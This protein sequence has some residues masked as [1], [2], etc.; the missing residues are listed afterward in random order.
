VVDEVN[1]EPGVSEGADRS[2]PRRAPVLGV[3]GG[4]G[5]GKTY[6]VRQIQSRCAA[7][8]MR[9]AH[10]SFDAY[11]HDLQ[12]LTPAQRSAMNFDH[13][14]SLDG[15]LFAVHVSRLATGEPIEVP[16]YDF[17]THARTADTTVVGPADIVVLDGILLYAFESVRAGIDLSVYLD[18]PAG[19][20]LD[21]R[22]ARDTVER[23]RDVADV[24]RQWKEFV[25]PMHA[26]FVE[27]FATSADVVVRY[28]DDRN[29]LL[30]HVMSRLLSLATNR[31]SALAESPAHD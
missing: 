21:R 13:P 23:G 15:E 2:T 8:G 9:V 25:E 5:A 30:D 20:R 14:D 1:S 11:Y 6:L 16:L 19:L 3:C 22:V 12:H 7:I 27:P 18:V 28:G 26:Q 29:E 10:V 24:E 4:S 17:S 31:D